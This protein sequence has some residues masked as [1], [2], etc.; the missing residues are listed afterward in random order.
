M[1]NDRDIGLFF[2]P[3]NLKKGGIKVLISDQI[4]KIKWS[5]SNKSRLIEL[6][7]SFTKIG[8]EL[9]IKAEDLSPSS[10][11]KVKVQCDYCKKIFEKDYGSYNKEIRKYP[12][13]ACIKCNGK[14]LKDV[15][16]IEESPRTIKRLKDFCNEK[17][18]ILLINDSDLINHKTKIKYICPIHGEQISTPDN[19]LHGHG[20]WMCKNDHIGN[21]LRRP[22]EDV[23]N[24]IES[25]NGNKL[26]NPEDYKDTFT[27][28]L[29]IKCGRCGNIYTTALKNYICA[30]VTTC[31]KCSYVQSKGEECISNYLKE[32]NIEYVQEKRFKDCKDN[33]PLP[34]DF[35]IPKYNKCIEYDGSQHY[36]PRF[37]KKNF[38][39]CKK[40]D[41]IKNQYCT[42][43]GIDLIRIPYWDKENINKILD[44][45]LNIA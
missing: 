35:Y 40:H 41:Q 28:N 8:N 44:E 23:R 3:K 45:K 37:G 33:K 2:M 16:S 7:Y 36:V 27:H 11:T 5:S 17:G 21:V 43:K 15:L 30:D 1:L 38:E 6:G 39:I 34:F 9:D 42:D 29:K 19:M 18:Y 10:K 26:L 24:I 14:K 31:R 4:V 13:C 22:S 25:K 32:H 12:K 20:C